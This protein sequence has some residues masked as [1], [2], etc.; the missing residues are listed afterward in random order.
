[1]C[2]LCRGHSGCGPL[3]NLETAAFYQLSAIAGKKLMEH[4]GIVRRIAWYLCSV[5]YGAVRLRESDVSEGSETVL[6]QRI[7]AGAQ[8]LYAGLIRPHGFWGVAT[9][10]RDD[11]LVR[12]ER[13][14]Q[15]A[16][17]IPSDLSMTWQ[18]ARIR[19]GRGDSRERE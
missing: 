16:A 19:L 5:P 1:V 4:L 8:R 11:R 3:S 6:A 7:A 12:G 17:A 14:E 18:C 9:R 15:H 2:E 10:P 13:A